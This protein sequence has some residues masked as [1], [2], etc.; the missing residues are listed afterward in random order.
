MSAAPERLARAIEVATRELEAPTS[1]AFVR[2]GRAPWALDAAGLPLVA[3]EAASAPPRGGVAFGAPGRDD[4]ARW[5]EALPLG[6]LGAHVFASPTPGVRGVLERVARLGWREPPIA[7]EQAS[8]EL[9]LAGLRALR[10]VALDP[11]R[12]VLAVIGQR[13]H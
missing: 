5:L 10:V 9:F 7:L 12:G 2:L 11:R 3:L 8:T 13:R 4:V 6:A 1:G